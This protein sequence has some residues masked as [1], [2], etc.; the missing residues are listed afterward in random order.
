[1]NSVHYGTDQVFYDLL[2]KAQSGN[3]AIGM[4]RGSLLPYASALNAGSRIEQGRQFVPKRAILGYVYQWGGGTS[5]RG[6]WDNVTKRYLG[7]QFHIKG[8]LHYGWA[9]LNVKI[10]GVNVTAKL[11]GYAYETI[12]NKPIIAGKTHGKDSGTLGRLALGA[13]RR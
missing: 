3:A 7:L 4:M 6:P 11:T 2:E 13:S 10:S 5:S 1:V 12:P 8:K 9:R